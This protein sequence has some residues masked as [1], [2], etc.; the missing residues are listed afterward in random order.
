MEM[1]RWMDAVYYYNEDEATMF[2]KMTD[3]ILKI[4]TL[5]ETSSVMCCVDGI[6]FCSASF[7]DNEII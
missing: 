7:M 6:I 1:D 3:T 2:F 5:C 4:L